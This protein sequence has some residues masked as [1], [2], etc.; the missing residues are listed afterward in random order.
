MSSFETV[1]A[2][3]TINP[4]LKAHC[5]FI[6]YA[7]EKFPLH[8]HD[9]Y[10]I[11]LIA[12]GHIQHNI[13]GQNEILEEG[14][15]VFIRPRDCHYYLP[16]QDEDCLY[17]NFK[18]QTDLFDSFIAYFSLE[19]YKEQLLSQK[20]PPKRL[21]N[22][23]EKEKLYRNFEKLN[24]TP[25]Q[26]LTVYKDKMRRFMIDLILN[27]FY[28]QDNGL[29]GDLPEWMSILCRQIQRDKNFLEGVD[30]LIQL[31]GKT[32][33]H[34]SRCFQKYLQ[35]T[36][37]DYINHLKLNYA[38]NLLAHTDMKI[39]DISLECGFYSLSYFYKIFK[40]CYGITAA[41]YRRQNHLL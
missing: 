3:M 1:S 10:E 23:Y 38:A 9:F 30:G 31:S 28:N 15:L 6:S 18:F 36:P 5:R 40:E 37:T 7:S 19:T 16:I 27:Y 4:Y 25:A 24:D 35:T 13:N 20:M 8:D 34:L 41:Q 21:L 26:N 2:K 22:T 11:F 39:L 32:Q 12:K 33:E 17:I 14:S 29:T